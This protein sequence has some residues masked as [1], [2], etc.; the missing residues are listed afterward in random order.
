MINKPLDQVTKDEILAIVENKVHEGQRLEFK[1]SFP[2]KDN[3]DERTKFLCTVASLAN[4]MGGDVIFGIAERR[5]DKKRTGETY[6]KGLDAAGFD[7]DKER[8]R[9]T[10][11]ILKGIDPRVG[12]VGFRLVEGLPEGPVVVMR[13]PMSLDAPHMVVF[14]ELNKFYSRHS[15]GRYTLGVR[16]IRQAFLASDLLQDRIRAFRNQRITAI[17]GGE[18]PVILRPEAKIVLHVIPYSA[19]DRPGSIDLAAA[20]GRRHELKTI[21]DTNKTSRHNLDGFVVYGG[22][23]GDD[24][25]YEAYTQVFRVG[26]V[27]AVNPHIL[28]GNKRHIDGPTSIPSQYYEEAIIAALGSMLKLLETSGGE[29]PISIMLSLAGVKGLVMA[30]GQRWM[31]ASQS[32]IDRDLLF[33]PEVVVEGYGP[34]AEEILKPIF[35]AVWQAAGFEKNLNYGEDGHRHR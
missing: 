28:E 35:E 21:G 30:L 34:T 31:G 3:D 11:S 32:G 7:F 12:R 13:V 29:P 6:V 15:G 14:N 33:L 1:E 19:L 4:S 17:V 9:L 16:E 2:K 23:S 20:H 5:Q 22:Q 27:E 26:V 24:P 8:N 10:E 18:T 25:R